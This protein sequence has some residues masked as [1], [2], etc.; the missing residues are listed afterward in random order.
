MT[1]YDR[2][3]EAL[4]RELEDIRM[5]PDLFPDQKATL[6]REI[7]SRLR[8]VERDEQDEQRWREEGSQNGW[9]S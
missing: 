9:T 1:A 4:E 2:E 5:D 8:E 6:T 3:I 7:M